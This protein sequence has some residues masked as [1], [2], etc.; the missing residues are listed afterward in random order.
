MMAFPNQKVLYR[1]DSRA[2]LSVVSDRFHVVEPRQ[3][4]EFYSGQS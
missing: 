4:L 3:I 1:S 2:P